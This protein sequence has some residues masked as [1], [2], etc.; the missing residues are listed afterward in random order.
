MQGL[1][2]MG[3]GWALDEISA[4]VEKTTSYNICEQ[5]AEG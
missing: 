1:E 5:D 3:G 4:F 2:T